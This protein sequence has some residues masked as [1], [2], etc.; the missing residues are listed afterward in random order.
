MIT[1][2]QATLTHR[3]NRI[4]LHRCDGALASLLPGALGNCNLVAIMGTY[5][6]GLAKETKCN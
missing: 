5:K 1:N 4:D 2:E 6:P 3:I